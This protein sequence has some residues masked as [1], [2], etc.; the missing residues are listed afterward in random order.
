MAANRKM[1]VWGAG[2]PRHLTSPNNHK[3]PLAW[4]RKAVREGR[5]FRV[6]C[7]SMG[8]VMDGEVPQEWREELWRIIDATPHLDWQ[9][10]TKRPENYQRY[11]PKKFAHNNVWFG[12]TTEDQHYFDLRWPAMVRL[13][14]R[15]PTAPLFIS[16]EP[17]LGPLSIAGTSVKPDWIIF[18]GESGSGARTMDVQWARDIR[19]ECARFKIP[20]FMKQMSNTSIHKAKHSIPEDLKIRQYPDDPN[21][22]WA[23]KT[24]APPR[25]KIP[26]EMRQALRTANLVQIQ[27]AINEPT[28]ADLLN[29]RITEVIR[30][31]CAEWHSKP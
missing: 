21:A 28:L 3:E 18:G 17:S 13:H 20:F 16:Y 29:Q 30:T 2:V 1:N 24:P 31:T 8:D 11:L 19:D 15:F 23:E 9:L 14:E 7:L 4:E 27:T 5:R 6:F 12:T 25:L 26:K 22:K 10:L